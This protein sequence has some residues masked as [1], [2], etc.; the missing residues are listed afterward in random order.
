[1]KINFSD[2][3]CHC[4]IGF[5]SKPGFPWT[6]TYCFAKT[7]QCIPSHRDSQTSQTPQPARQTERQ[8]SRSAHHPRQPDSQK[9]RQ[10]DSQI[11]RQPA[12]QPAIH[13]ASHPGH[14]TTPAS[15]RVRKTDSQ[16]VK[17]Q[18]ASLPESQIP[19]QP[20]SQ[21]GKLTTI[22]ILVKSDLIKWQI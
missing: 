16:T 7:S 2:R 13:P 3:T 6:Q 21:A 20:A 10:L 8:T 22:Q 1:M 14:P 15:Q 18:T 9:D 17:N 19:R 4:Q 12:C 11:T 5:A